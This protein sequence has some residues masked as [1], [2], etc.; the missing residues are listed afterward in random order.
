MPVTFR[1]KS[2]TLFTSITGI[3]VIIFNLIVSL[4]IL[5]VEMVSLWDRVEPYQKCT[6]S[7]HSWI[8]TGY[9]IKAV[10]YPTPL[11]FIEITIYQYLDAKSFGNWRWED[12]M[13]SISLPLSISFLWPSLTP[14]VQ[15]YFSS[16]P[17]AAVKI[18]DGSS[19][20]HQKNYWYQL[21]LLLSI[22]HVLAWCW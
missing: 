10:C 6:A 5:L 1:I 13:I 14:L 19:N 18:K 12:G 2:L 4:F 17:T 16:K 9:D 11:M 8:T 22:Q 15:I 3:N 7:H 21:V 20:F